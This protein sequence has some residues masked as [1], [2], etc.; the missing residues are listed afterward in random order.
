M[1]DNNNNPQPSADKKR[2]PQA[3]K[4][5]Y[6]LFGTDPTPDGGRCS[7]CNEYTAHTSFVYDG[8]NFVKHLCPSCERMR[9]RERRQEKRGGDW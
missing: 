4:K 1:A 3:W 9:L 2:Q 5:S 8:S 7:S 6:P